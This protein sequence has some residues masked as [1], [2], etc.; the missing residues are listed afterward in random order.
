MNHL[1]LLLAWMQVIQPV[2]TTPEAITQPTQTKTAVE[3]AER[4]PEAYEH[5]WHQ[6]DRF[7]AAQAETFAEVERRALGKLGTFCALDAKGK[8]FIEYLPAEN[9]WVPI[10]APHYMFINCF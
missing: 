6:P 5:F 4:C 7:H 1:L 2:T 8:V 10:D 9:A 3:I